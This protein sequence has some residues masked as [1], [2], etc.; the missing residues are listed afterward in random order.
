MEKL[1]CLL[2]ATILLAA[3]PLPGEGEDAR[4]WRDS[5]SDRT[6]E[7]SL[8][9]V[10][11]KQVQLRRADGRLVT[12]PLERLSP[13]DQDYLA[14][15][16]KKEPAPAA[17]ARHDP[18][19][20]AAD[21]VV[22]CSIE[23]GGQAKFIPGMVFYSA[24]EKAF[25]AIQTP[26]YDWGG[27]LGKSPEGDPKIVILWGADNQHQVPA[28][29]VSLQRNRGRWVLESP[30][31]KMPAP[32]QPLAADQYQEQL[33]V[34]V[35]GYPAA[36]SKEA[37]RREQQELTLSRI[38]Y[39]SLD[40]VVQM[41]VEG[42]DLTKLGTAVLLDPVGRPIGF[43]YP[44]TNDRRQEQ[45]VKTRMAFP[46][47]NLL[48]AR[49]PEIA[50]FGFALVAREDTEGKWEFTLKVEDP[51][52]VMRSPRLFV[53]EGTLFGASRPPR[54]STQPAIPDARE[55]RL[56]ASPAGAEDESS[57][58]KSLAVKL[59]KGQCTTPVP[60]DL[61]KFIFQTQ[62]AY[63][64]DEGKTVFLSP[65]TRTLPRPRPGLPKRN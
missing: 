10:E 22:L 14:S 49:A 35:L 31:E 51:C 3:T 6:I 54:L 33:K 57:Q 29:L 19:A 58:F 52:N 38:F 16:P 64:D 61:S 18:A 11:N 26:G 46:I 65:E 13:E 59:W 27:G 36:N 42:K 62:L 4:K 28:K 47:Q 2:L 1:R 53:Q 32:L 50:D 55:I 45:P 44:I 63:E 48:Y 5:T 21:A 56:T 60:M 12:V 15:L 43:L 17:L 30:A 25:V 7:A 23:W 8:V 9:K 37:P 39:R 24:G 34:A 40:D 20:T 41:E